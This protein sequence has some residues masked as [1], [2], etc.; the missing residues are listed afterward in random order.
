[1]C[2]RCAENAANEKFVEDHVSKSDRLQQMIVNNER[3]RQEEAETRNAKSREK[4]KKWAVMQGG[5]ATL[6][7]IF[8]GVRLFL[9]MGPPSVMSVAEV[10]AQELQE[11]RMANCM[12]VFWEIAAVLQNNQVPDESLRCV[13]PGSPNIVVREG[14]DII[15][16]HP[17]PQLLGYNNIYVSRSNPV[18]MLE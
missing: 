4:D 17:Q 14:N 6:G 8:I 18:P 15:V 2:E 10:Q 1:M 5:V 9:T 3:H 11:S 7:A 13:D 12:L 16:R